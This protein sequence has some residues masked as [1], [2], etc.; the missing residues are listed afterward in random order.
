MSSHSPNE[1]SKKA[2]GIAGR[3]QR[4]GPLMVGGRFYLSLLAGF[5][6]CSR[7]FKQNL[8][9]WSQ[10]T[11]HVLKKGLET[12]HLSTPLIRTCSEG[13][14]PIRFTSWLAIET[15]DLG[16]L[17]GGREAAQWLTHTM[18]WLTMSWVI[19]DNHLNIYIYTHIY[20]YSYVHLKHVCQ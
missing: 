3:C 20:I 12:T 13:P 2:A 17:P 15:D 4:I 14:Q 7:L 6:W 16:I 18:S 1:L 19:L 8:G 9:R 10:K 5:I 11:S